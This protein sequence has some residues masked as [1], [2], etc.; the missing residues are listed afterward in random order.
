MMD[1]RTHARFQELLAESDECVWTVMRWASRNG[2]TVRKQ[3]MAIAPTVDD[4][5]DYK[6]DADL[7][8]CMPVE[9]KHLTCDFTG[10]D[11]WPFRNFIVDSVS[12]FETKVRRP[13]RYICVNRAMTHLAIVDVRATRRAW[14]VERKNCKQF[15]DVGGLV[16]DFY[17]VDTGLVTSWHSI[18]G[19]GDGR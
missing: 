15:A 7:E 17:V 6:D 11:D 14:Y 1:E 3:P 10:P 8:L 5:F 9:V 19:D 18:K 12:N 16:Q 2:F 4:R 13:W